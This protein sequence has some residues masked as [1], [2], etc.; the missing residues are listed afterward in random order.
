MGKRGIGAVGVV[1]TFNGE[2]AEESSRTHEG[3]ACQSDEEM[4]CKGA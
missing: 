2:M 4:A 1:E 3:D